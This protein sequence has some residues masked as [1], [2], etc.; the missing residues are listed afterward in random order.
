MINRQLIVDEWRE[1]ITPNYNVP[2][3]L[4]DHQLD[5]MAL[6]HEGEHVFLGVPTGAGKTLPQLSTILTMPGRSFYS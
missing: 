4:F 5:A 6:L 3:N 2:L 1:K